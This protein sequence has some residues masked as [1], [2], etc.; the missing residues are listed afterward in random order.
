M[1]GQPGVSDTDR[2]VDDP[3][4][5]N[6]PRSLGQI[7]SDIST[8]LTQLMHQEMD[9]AKTELREEVGKAGKGVGLLAGAGV[10]GHLALLFASLA[11]T[12]LLDNWMPVEAAALITAAIW[13]IAAAVMAGTGRKAVKESNP[14][15]PQTQRTLKEDA[16]WAKAQ[17]S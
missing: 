7:V 1:D 5:P 11:L 17:K 13:G 15:L 12:W 4:Q 10:A 2:R 8:H 9:L 6:D 14:Q 16:Q 3:T